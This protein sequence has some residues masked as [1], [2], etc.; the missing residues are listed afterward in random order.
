MLDACAGLHKPLDELTFSDTFANVGE[1]EGFH[2]VEARGTV[3][4]ASA[5]GRVEGLSREQAA[6]SGR[7]QRHC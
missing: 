4:S 2:H 7:L 5:N 3:E 1:E 6:Y